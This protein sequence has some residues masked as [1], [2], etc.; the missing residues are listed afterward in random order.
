MPLLYTR[1][2]I[3]QANFTK[4]THLKINAYGSYRKEKES[5]HISLKNNVSYSH[6]KSIVYGLFNKKML[7]RN[8]SV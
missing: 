6:F 8:A 1:M 4:L 2:H 5:S 3:V 7:D